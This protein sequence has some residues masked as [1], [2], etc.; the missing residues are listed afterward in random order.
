MLYAKQGDWV[1]IHT[2]IL[3]AGER[4]PQVPAET[5]MVP[6]EMKAKGFLLEEQAAVGMAVTIRTLAGR[7]L[8]GIL[9]AVNPRYAVDYGV[10]QP[11]LMTIGGEVRTILEG[12]RDA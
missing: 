5:G 7:K 9:I 4:A 6:L 11:E 3:P 2:V 10:P 8:Q 1:Q 12:K